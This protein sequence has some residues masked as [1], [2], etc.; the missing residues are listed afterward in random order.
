MRGYDYPLCRAGVTQQ[1][2]TDKMRTFP[3]APGKWP[4]QFRLPPISKTSLGADRLS[5]RLKREP[6]L[7]PNPM[8]ITGSRLRAASLGRADLVLMSP[9]WFVTELTVP[10]SRRMPAASR[11]RRAS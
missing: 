10:A 11:R 4:V 3:L 8:P 6:N 2:R 5:G 7:W 9:V 1:E